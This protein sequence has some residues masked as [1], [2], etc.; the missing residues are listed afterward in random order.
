MTRAPRRAPLHFDDL[1]SVAKAIRSRGGRLSTPRRLVLEALFLA[2]G[3]VSAEYIADGL[4][5]RGRTLDAS[6]VYRNLQVLEELGVVHHVHLGHGPGLYALETATTHEYLVCMRCDRVDAVAA[7]RFDPVRRQI[8][9]E[10]GY[11]A[12]FGHFA[13]AGLCGACAAAEGV[14]DG[15]DAHGAGHTHEHTH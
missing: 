11:E 10:F 12:A 5:G 4:N 6:S 7:E 1:E 13:I 15:H 8:R 14:G 2:E 9:D 3:P